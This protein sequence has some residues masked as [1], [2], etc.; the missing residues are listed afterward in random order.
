[1]IKKLENLVRFPPPPSFS[2][3]LLIKLHK[4]WSEFGC[5][6]CLSFYCYF[7]GSNSISSADL[8]G[9]DMDNSS[10]DLTADIINRLSFQVGL[11]T[12]LHVTYHLHYSQ[13]NWEIR[14]NSF[15]PL[16]SISPSLPLFAILDCCTTFGLTLSGFFLSPSFLQAQHDISNLKNIAGETGKKLSSLASTLIT[17]LQ[18]RILWYYYVVLEYKKN[19]EFVTV[20]AKYVVN[21]KWVHYKNSF[22]RL[23]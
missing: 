11:A 22:K 6:F 23:K 21:V 1:M 8:F 4:F 14:W 20:P 16:G 17:D 18:D 15:F 9:H 12:S 7:Q 10:V 19:E 13:W 5:W 3:L 2:P